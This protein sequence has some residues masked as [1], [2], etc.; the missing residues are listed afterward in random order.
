MGGSMTKICKNHEKKE[1]IIDCKNCNRKYQ[2]VLTEV[3]HDEASTMSIENFINPLYTNTL[4]MVS[5]SDKEELECGNCHMSIN[6]IDM[7]QE[8]ESCSTHTCMLNCH[9]TKVA[10][11]VCSPN[12]RDCKDYA[13]WY[14][15]R[16]GY[17][18]CSGC[19][20][21]WCGEEDGDGNNSCTC[22][23]S[24]ERKS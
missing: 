19:S 1:G 2:Y 11:V 13:N 20:E 7:G 18:C 15:D 21:K 16:D 9:Y 8:E 4:I 12:C 14:T 10:I 17:V 3:I 23:Q 6:I 24:R 22:F 5:H